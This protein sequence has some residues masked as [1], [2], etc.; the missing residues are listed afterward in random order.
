MNVLSAVEP[1][2]PQLSQWFTTGAG[3]G[4]VPTYLVP[5]MDWYDCVLASLLVPSV[6]GVLSKD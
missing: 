1:A 6:L 4:R 2:S 5:V 3:R